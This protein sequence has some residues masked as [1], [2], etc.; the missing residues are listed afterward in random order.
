MMCKF[1]EKEDSAVER[2][3]K[4]VDIQRENEFKEELLCCIDEIENNAFLKG[5]KYAISVLED[6]ITK[7]AN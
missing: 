5:Y 1:E 7:K 2:L 6:G 4:F 3:L